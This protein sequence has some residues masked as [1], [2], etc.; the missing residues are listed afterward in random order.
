M[1]GD[2]R[3]GA[4]LDLL[5]KST[6][7]VSASFLAKELGVSRQIIVGDVALLR[8]TGTVIFA[9]P[10][11]YVLSMNSG[12]SLIYKV[13]C[14]HLNSETEDEL[15]IFVDCGITVLDVIVE[16]PVYGQLTGLLDISS[17][18]EVK[19]FIDRCSKEK[20][21]SLCELTDG[22]HIHTI[23]CPSEDSYKIAINMLKERGFLLE[24]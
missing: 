17:R 20:A 8:A 9:T 10:K 6:S 13:A 16:H 5:K 21:H 15:N 7:P 1:T 18:I 22:I 3:R 4:V 24:D 12:D 14:C 2:E 23:E 11:G 19:E